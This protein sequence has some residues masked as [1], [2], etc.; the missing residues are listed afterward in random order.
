MFFTLMFEKLQSHVVSDM[1]NFAA[2][3][4]EGIH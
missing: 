1:K 4:N 2:V 3:R